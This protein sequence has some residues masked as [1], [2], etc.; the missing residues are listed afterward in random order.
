MDKNEID[1]FLLL[2][3]G[4]SVIDKLT[5]SNPSTI[6][7]ENN[8]VENE[9]AFQLDHVHEDEYEGSAED[10]EDE[11]KYKYAQSYERFASGEVDTP[12][13]ILE[14]DFDE[15]PEEEI[16]VNQDI[17]A[18][19]T[20][21]ET[22]SAKANPAVKNAAKSGFSPDKYS[23][24][25]SSNNIAIP[26]Y[27]KE[28]IYFECDEGKI[29]NRGIY[30][31][32]IKK[33][34]EQYDLLKHPYYIF[35]MEVYR[36]IDSNNEAF[37][38]FQFQTIADEVSEVFIPNAHLNNFSKHGELQQAG[39][40]P[41]PASIVSRLSA[42]ILLALKALPADKKSFIGYSQPGWTADGKFHIRPGHPKH[43][44]IG[45]EY[46]S[47]MKAGTKEAQ[48]ETYRVG[49]KESLLVGFNM[50]AGVAGYMRGK[51]FNSSVS[52]MIVYHGKKN[53]GKSTLL[54]AIAAIQGKP[55]TEAKTNMF[56]GKSTEASLDREFAGNNH[57]VVALDE[58][59]DVLL[60][61]KT[62]GIS[63]L[64]NFG[65]KGGNTRMESGVSTTY[66]YDITLF[67]SFNA[68]YEETIGGHE[69][70]EALGSRII[71]IDIMHP[72]L[73]TFKDAKSANNFRNGLLENYGHMYED[74]IDYIINNHD[75]IKEKYTEM[76]NE[77]F[78]DT[79]F[80]FLRD[81]QPRALEFFSICYAGA[82]ALG[83]ILGDEECTV[84]AIE[85]INILVDE[86]RSE[87]IDNAMMQEKER[88]IVPHSIYESLKE[89][90][91]TNPYRFHWKKYAFAEQHDE[92]NISSHDLHRLQKQ[93]AKDINARHSGNNV[94]LGII[95]INQVMFHEDDFQG[96]LYLNELGYKEFEKA[97]NI[98]KG[99]LIRALKNI[100][101]IALPSSEK[102]DEVKLSLNLALKN[103]FLKSRTH[104]IILQEVNV[105][106][107]S[108]E[109]KVQETTVENMFAEDDVDNLANSFA[110]LKS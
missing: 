63:R 95:E 14:H 57:G 60:S 102:T 1:D 46:G 98:P 2:L 58:S 77:I 20:S 34:G 108:N 45:A 86:Y 100:N 55:T 99:N 21:I 73:N 68:D 40:P 92:Y 47:L 65:N 24:Q 43:I 42:L 78:N 56:S 19:E 35:P 18:K 15:E 16:Q 72:K 70:S 104:K 37:V 39:F 41:P 96:F 27:Q 53:A 93:K 50:A 85:A 28:T 11:L 87:N 36:A 12:D 67:A 107:E 26:T 33:S 54:Q 8:P 30:L 29:T 49:I 13:P 74:I 3:M 110:K 23:A 81:D 94:T 38:K 64:M 17:E 9:K 4:D 89:F 101:L 69:K 51:I 71:G 59:D 91:K 106:S 82:M 90:V 109:I 84:R 88:K 7:E 83:D 61:N 80:Y 22:Q 25:Q 32:N 66:S 31:R 10:F 5:K 48:Y 76:Y 97:Y 75:K 62:K 52:Q 103:S 44:G 6:T 79:A 105:L